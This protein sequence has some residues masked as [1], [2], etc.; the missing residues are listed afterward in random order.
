MA[1]LATTTQTRPEERHRARGV[2]RETAESR[3]GT[4]EP[5][6]AGWMFRR[7]EISPHFVSGASVFSVGAANG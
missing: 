7:F 6:A 2:K 5:F 3:E 4:R 1:Q